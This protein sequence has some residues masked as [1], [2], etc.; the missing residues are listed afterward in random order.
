M[1]K[2]VER[3]DNSPAAVEA[4][5][6]I[7]RVLEAERNGRATLEEAR[8]RAA[9]RVERA[10]AQAIEVANRAER[11]SRAIQV[12]FERRVEANQQA[13][14]AEIAALAERAVAA[15]DTAIRRLALDAVERLAADLTGGGDD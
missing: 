9:A 2:S 8:E 13:V 1:E 10:R 3:T 12:A 6:A 4:E 14:D 5:A 11:R 7:V 15:E